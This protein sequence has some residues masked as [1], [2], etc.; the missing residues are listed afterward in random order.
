MTIQEVLERF[1]QRRIK[2]GVETLFH[3]DELGRA[4]ATIQELLAERGLRNVTVTP[5]V[6]PMLPPPSSLTWPPSA[7][8]ITFQV[9]PASTA[10][11]RAE[12]LGK[13]SSH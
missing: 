7:V 9:T 3:E 6:E 1:K 2:L 8:K 4:A 12:L 10:L 11:R 5:L 13:R